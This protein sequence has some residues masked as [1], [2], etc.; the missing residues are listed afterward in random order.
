MTLTR[1][2][3]C[4]LIQGLISIH[5]VTYP[6]NVAKVFVLLWALSASMWQVVIRLESFIHSH[7]N[8]KLFITHPPVSHKYSLAHS[9]KATVPVSWSVSFS[10]TLHPLFSL[11]W[12]L[13]LCFVP[14]LC[15]VESLA[16]TFSNMI[17]TS[18]THTTE[19]HDTAIHDTTSC[20]IT[21]MKR[22]SK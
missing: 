6:C 13:S 16:P 11:T 1:Y 7:H 9:Q 21:C 12:P 19:A 20:Q 2:V 22:Q 3:L 15:P 17:Q 10:E 18:R 4:N 5:W 14:T 8:Q